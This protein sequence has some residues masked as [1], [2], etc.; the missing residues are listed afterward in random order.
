MVNL[1]S[2]YC[3]IPALLLA[4][5]A[6]AQSRPGITFDQT[7]Q[8]VTTTPGHFDSSTTVVH[9]TAAGS[10]ARID[11][12][13]GTLGP[14][15]IGPFLSGT[16][17]VMILRDGGT[18]TVFINP[19]KKQYMSIK[20]FEMIQGFR[21]MLEGMGG[22]MNVDTS[23]TRVSFDSLGPGPAIDGHPTLNYRL[24]TVIKM[25]VSMM[26]QENVIEDQSTQDIQAATDIGEF[27]DAVTA[28][29]RFAEISQSLGMA[30][31]FFD[32]VVATRRKMRG[33][34]LRSVKRS[35]RSARGVTHVVTET[36]DTKNV[37]RLTVPDSL[38]AIPG[39]YKPV[40]LPSTSGTGT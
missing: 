2:A 30:K 19:D 13:Q 25:T 27:A 37:K 29:N 7:L 18:Q 24:T 34:P 8:T 10:D 38:F 17:L 39:D 12:E 20:P 23:V 26:G 33:F 35:T 4:A 22:S 6:T 16:H 28:V 11:V 14:S 32:K 40:T 31:D 5:A 21:K 15:S 36:I 3:A 9:M 1:K